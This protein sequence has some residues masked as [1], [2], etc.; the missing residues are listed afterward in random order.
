MSHDVIACDA[1][2]IGSEGQENY[3]EKRK[4]VLEI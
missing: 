2:V 3:T 1:T 4:T